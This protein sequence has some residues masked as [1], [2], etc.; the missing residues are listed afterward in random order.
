MRAPKSAIYLTQVCRNIETIANA[1]IVNQHMILLT[2]FIFHDKLAKLI[3]ISALLSPI[4]YQNKLLST[5]GHFF[6]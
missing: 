6:S 1:S 3:I 2:S 5:S 4:L